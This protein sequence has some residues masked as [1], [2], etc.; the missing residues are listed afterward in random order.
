MIVSDV[1]RQIGGRTGAAYAL[2]SP[3]DLAR[4]IEAGLPVEAADALVERGVLSAA[5]LHGLILPRRTLSHRRRHGSLTAPESDRLIRV[6]RA[7]A[8]AE[9]TLGSAEKAHAWLRRSNR[10]LDGAEPLSLL[11]TDQGARAVEVALERLAHG[12]FA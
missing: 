5:E 3:L 1:T 12:V 6:A 9:E 7:A 4:A 2:N 10:S 11:S 8:L